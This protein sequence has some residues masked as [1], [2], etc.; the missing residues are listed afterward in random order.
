MA[1]FWVS[2]LLVLV[3]VSGFSQAPSSLE[4]TVTAVLMD[5]VQVKTSDGS[6]HQAVL[7]A[8]VSV[9]KR[10]AATWKDI[11]PGDW[12]GVDSKP[13]ADGSQESV[14]INVFSPGIIAKVRKGQFTMASGDL[15]TNAPVDQITS[16][17]GGPGL[18]LKN[19]DAMVSFRLTDKTVV[20]RLVDAGTP[21]IKPGEMV[22][23]RGTVNADGSLE[24][25][26]VS[27]TGP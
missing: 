21:D 25:A 17:T 24:A 4:G 2:I 16:G 13:G 19:A 15:M 3:T 7:S 6:S 14:A 12:V 5:R 20:H 22:T 10:V 27:I 18:V 8:G 26:N 1:R 9:T 11:H 23:V